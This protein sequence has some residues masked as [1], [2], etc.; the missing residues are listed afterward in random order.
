M[1]RYA[2]G[3]VSLRK[4]IHAR[5]GVCGVVVVTTMHAIARVSTR[6]GEAN[7]A[8]EGGVSSDF[9][10]FL[11]SYGS[12]RHNRSNLREGRENMRDSCPQFDPDSETW[13]GFAIVRLVFFS[14]YWR[15]G[16]GGSYDNA[17]HNSHFD[18]Y[19]HQQ[20]PYTSIE[21]D[22]YAWCSLAS[23]GFPI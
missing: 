3:Q 1:T 12:S 2:N 22:R 11:Y 21:R 7:V 18:R 13:Q 16:T 17:C 14:R 19:W 8:G 6:T 10:C 5:T 20:H 4:D 9:N 15:G 23:L